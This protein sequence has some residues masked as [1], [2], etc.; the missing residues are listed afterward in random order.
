MRLQN[1]EHRH[2]LAS[3]LNSP[4]FYV[5]DVLELA[6]ENEE[7]SRAESV[8]TKIGVLKMTPLKI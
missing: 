1:P 7:K 4:N 8:E 5:W 2:P 6:L 3:N